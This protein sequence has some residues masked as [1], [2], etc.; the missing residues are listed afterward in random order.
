MTLRYLSLSAGAHPWRWAA[1]LVLAAM[2]AFLIAACGDDE[3][4][5]QQQAQGDAQ[6][7]QQEQDQPSTSS[8]G[9]SSSADDD[10]Q[11]AQAQDQQQQQQESQPAVSDAPLK[12]G[13]LADFSGPLAEFGPAIQTGVD[14]ALQHINAAGGVLGSPV[15]VVTGDTSLDAAQGVEEA[16]RLV[17]VEQ[18]SAIVGPLASGITLAVAESVTGPAG[19]PTISP[20]AT[21]PQLSIAEDDDFLFRS[22]VSDAAQGP[23]LAQLA[24][25][26]G[27]RNVAVLFI[28]DAYG[29]GLADAFGAAWG[30]ESTIVGI[31][32]GQTSYLSELQQASA[33][34]ADVLV[35]IAFPTQAE[36]FIR[37]AIEND[38]FDRFLFVDGTKSQDLIAAIGDQYLNE[39]KGTAPSSGPETES[40][41]SF[42]TAYEAEYGELSPLPFIREAYDATIAIALAAEAAGSTDPGAIRDALRDVAAPGGTLYGAGADSVGAALAAIRSGDAVDYDG[43]AT[44]LNWND[45]GDVTSGYIGIWQ[46]ENGGITEL[47]ETAFDL[48][49]PASVA[50]PATPTSDSPMTLAYLADFSGPL[51]E[52][53]TTVENG[54]VLAV[55]HVN[56]NGGIL[57]QPVNLITGDTQLDASLAIEEARRLIEIEGAH[58]IVGALSSVVTL[59]VAESVSGPAGVPTISPSATSPQ[60]SLAND[61]GYLFR[62]TTSDAAQGPVLA[63]LAADEGYTHVGV[64]Y[65]NDPYGQGLAEAFGRAFEAMGHSANLISIEDAQ[66]SY[67]SELNQAAADGAQ[68]L[69]VAAFPTQSSVFIREA[70]EQGI[71]DRFVFTD[72]SRSVDLISQIGAQYLE[73][74]KGTAPVGGPETESLL[75]YNDAYI[76][77][78]G[79]LPQLPFVNNAYD[80]AIALM[81]AAEA[82]GSFD[83]AA[84]R[85]ALPRIS[86][87]GGE[88]VTPGLDGI[89][90]ALEIIR[91]GGEVNYEGAATTLDWNAD[92]DVTSGYIG[93]WQYSDGA[94]EELDEVFFDLNQ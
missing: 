21:S 66:P 64:V 26:E 44:S 32:D 48:S 31:Q 45:V 94:I 8:S 53:G 74:M 23:V 37:E 38:I 28:N 19:V 55:A 60:L 34:G 69:V 42:N 67:L 91:S 79:E 59:A 78:Y 63:Q 25:D 36:I 54:V 27:Y 41:A 40:L 24:L 15:E 10:Q 20:S 71:F 6:E 84:I 57:G 72:G 85:D 5:Q 11:Q 87:P 80:A 81:L 43:A 68:A 33:N 22:T 65:I 17:N 75:N 3:D 2:A 49:G 16:R 58:A 61:N 56:L 39:M 18:V 73:G 47:A 77:F 7:E 92:G 4:Q 30:G 14:L 88:V 29:Q 89:A 70:L 62:S 82:A 93:I 1:L 51:A 9:T 13:Y 46:Y 90:R 86:S 50:T 52:Y 35:A 12:I 76:D 83:G